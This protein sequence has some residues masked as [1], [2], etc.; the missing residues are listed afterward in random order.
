MRSSGVR[1]ALQT[2]PVVSRISLSTKRTLRSGGSRRLRV[3]FSNRII[4]EDPSSINSTVKKSFPSEASQ[5]IQTTKMSCG[6]EPEKSILATRCLTAMVFTKQ[7]TVAKRFGILDLIAPIRSRVSWS[8]PRIQIPFTSVP[9]V[10]STEPIPSAVFI[11]PP[12]VEK[13]G[14]KS[15]LS[16]IKRVSLIW[17]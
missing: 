4:T 15:Y 9:Q 17:R 5:P 6:L 7:P 10:D 3:D 16:M 8:T 14:S 11:R 13:P 12:M 1:S 2:C